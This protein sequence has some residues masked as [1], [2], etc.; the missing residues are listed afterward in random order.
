[1]HIKH[2]IP[3]RHFR[4]PRLGE[5]LKLPRAIKYAFIILFIYYLGWGIWV[6]FEPIYLKRIVGSYTHIGLIVMTFN[7]LALFFSLFLGTILDKIN[8]KKSIR[9]WLLFYLPFSYIFSKIK[10]LSHFLLF[11]AYHGIIATGLWISGE[12]YVRQHSPKKKA[13]E[14]M[15]LYDLSTILAVVIG[16]FIGAWLIYKIGFNIFYAISAFAFLALITSGI[17]PDHGRWKVKH[18]HPLKGLK[19][20]L[21]DLRKNKSLRRL[22][23]FLFVY[24]FVLATMPLVLPLFLNHIGAKLWQIGII[25]AISQVP[26]LF[27]GF[28]GLAKRKKAIISSSL[29]IGSALFLAMAFVK[30]ILAI[31]LLSLA[32]SICFS[33][34]SPIINGKLTE[35][36]PRQ[37][38]GE[39]TATLGA[40]RYL[41]ISLS[42]LFS[43]FISDLLGLHYV[44]LL[45]FVLFGLL[46]IS[47]KKIFK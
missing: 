3:F 19:K 36:M 11:K 13:I 25:Y 22:S 14:S 38:R 18:I 2:Y 4:L 6:A 43:G 34:I 42:S 41:S 26:F 39:L 9:F 47:L 21:K 8:K 28:F 10:A 15:A 33:A 16:G 12:A 29:L 23:A 45:N 1:M 35:A 24:V 20:E 17:L 5:F 7:F 37:K 31:F 30:N 40:L 27:E 44:F 32:I 46:F